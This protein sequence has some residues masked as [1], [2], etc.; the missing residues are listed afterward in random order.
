MI[1]RITFVVARNR[2]VDVLV[3]YAEFL[4][5]KYFDLKGRFYFGD[6]SFSFSTFFK[7]QVIKYSEIESI[8]RECYNSQ[9]SGIFMPV[10][11][12]QISS[13]QY[14]I[15]LKNGRNFIFRVSYFEEDRY[16]KELDDFNRKIY[17]MNALGV[18]LTSKVKQDVAASQERAMQ[19]E[20]PVKHFTLDSAVGALLERACI[21]L[22]DLTGLTDCENVKINRKNKINESDFVELAKLLSD[23]DKDVVSEVFTHVEQYQLYYKNKAVDYLYREMNENTPKDTVRWF[24]MIDVL[25]EHGYAVE[26]EYKE[27]DDFENIKNALDML[28]KK[29]G[30]EIDIKMDLSFLEADESVEELET[31]RILTLIGLNTVEQGYTLSSIDIDGDSYIL[32]LIPNKIYTRCENILQDT[33]FSL[34]SF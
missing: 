6:E 14:R 26:V 11:A 20:K 30:V 16:Q 4:Y 3:D 33:E 7:K 19:F 22:D 31:D 5:H 10:A 27:K 12:S 2:G 29:I 32:C 25:I 24:A 8:T 34:S 21:E 18:D 17:N 9:M 13:N 1:W 15:T 28:K 23:N